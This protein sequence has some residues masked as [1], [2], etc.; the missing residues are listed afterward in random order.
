MKASD[1]LTRALESEGVEFIFGIP[2]KENLDFLDS[3]SRSKF[4]LIT[5]ASRASGRV[6]GGHLWPAHWQARRVFGDSW[7]GR[8]QSRNCC[9]IRA[10]RRDAN[11]DE[12][13]TKAGQDQQARSLS[14]CRRGRHDAA[15]HQVLA[16]NP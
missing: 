13:R 16:A 5:H 14:D 6:Y 12:H 10:A 8:R 1:I 7:A 9:G 3:L 15:A 2:G 11:G 4:K